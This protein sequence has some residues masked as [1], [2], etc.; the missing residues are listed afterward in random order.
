MQQPLL[1][2]EFDSAGAVAYRSKSA[3]PSRDVTE[4]LLWPV[5]EPLAGR[6]GC[7]ALTAYMQAFFDLPKKVY[8]KPIG[9]NLLR[10]ENDSG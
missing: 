5:A 8:R 4:S 6:D 7:I 10:A 9:P 2:G 3:L 1:P